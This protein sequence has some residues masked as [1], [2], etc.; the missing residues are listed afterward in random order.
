[1]ENKKRVI[2]KSY[3]YEKSHQNVLL[4][5]YKQKNKTKGWDFMQNLLVEIFYD[6]DNY[7][8][9]FEEHCR[10]HV[11]HQAILSIL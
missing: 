8:I 3:R 11:Y 4:Y 5:K 6:A 2:E 10:N 9:A 1:M 7:C